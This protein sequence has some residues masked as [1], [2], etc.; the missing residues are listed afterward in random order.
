MRRAQRT[1]L[2]IACRTPLFRQ[3]LILTR[4]WRNVSSDQEPF[5]GPSSWIRPCSIT[6]APGAHQTSEL[7]S[8]RRT[9][10]DI[11]FDSPFPNMDELRLRP[12]VSPPMI[13]HPHAATSPNLH[14][15]GGA[16]DTACTHYLCTAST[17][18]SAKPPVWWTNKDERRML[19]TACVLLLQHRISSPMILHSFF[20]RAC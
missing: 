10:V 1:T 11:L 5:L 12:T 16:L 6:H 18:V 19:V 8:A 9:A 15:P 20:C 7:T 13:K 2:N 17:V 14:P 3:P 4:C